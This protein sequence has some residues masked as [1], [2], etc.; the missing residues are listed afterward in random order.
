MSEVTDLSVILV[1][2][3]NPTGKNIKID[4]NYQFGTVSSDF[5]IV[6]RCETVEVK[7]V[8]VENKNKCERTKSVDL[9]N[10]NKIKFGQ[11]LSEQQKSRLVKLIKEKYEAFQ[12]LE[13]DL[14]LTDL[15]DLW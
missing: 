12:L 3:L 2:V 5:S 9:S 1:N 6:E 13:S 4:A 11:N 15:I 8:I 10:L 14:G 7:S